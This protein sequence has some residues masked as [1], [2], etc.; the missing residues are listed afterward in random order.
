MWR[1]K[2]WILQKLGKHENDI[3]WSIPN[4]I[5]DNAFEKKNTIYNIERFLRLTPI[6]YKRNWFAWQRCVELLSRS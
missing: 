3:I 4:L 2:Y 5:C 1:W 6:N